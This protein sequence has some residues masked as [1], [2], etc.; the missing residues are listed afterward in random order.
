[1]LGTV[2]APDEPTYRAGSACD[3]KVFFIIDD[4]LCSAEVVVFCK[5]RP[6]DTIAKHEPV[7]LVLR[8]VRKTTR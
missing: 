1:M 4:R 2:V 8:G 6:T 3:V 7:E 5:T